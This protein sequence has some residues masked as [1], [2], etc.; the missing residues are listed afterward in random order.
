MDENEMLVLE[1]AAIFYQAIPDYLVK[2]AS[3]KA[4]QLALIEIID[5]LDVVE[6]NRTKDSFL[7][8]IQREIPYHRKR[9]ILHLVEDYHLTNKEGH[10]L[11]YL[12]NGQDVDYISE[13]LGI[14]AATTRTH[15]YN[16][17]RKLGIHSNRE[18]EYL[19][20]TYERQ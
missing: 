12:A 1:K 10:V 18:L 2:N 9:A 6:Y 3:K 8:P 20:R 16:I 14:A 17:Y 19:L 4:L 13:T 15:K 5:A 11:R 7:A